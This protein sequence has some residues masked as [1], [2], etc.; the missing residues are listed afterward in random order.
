MTGPEHQSLFS[1]CDLWRGRL[2]HPATQCRTRLLIPAPCRHE[3]VSCRPL[4]HHEPAKKTQGRCLEPGLPR[5]Y[6]SS[7]GNLMLRPWENRAIPRI[8]AL[9]QTLDGLEFDPQTRIELMRFAPA[10]REPLPA[11]YAR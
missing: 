6:P 7:A 1:F 11:P 5:Q 3:F 4:S 9:L 8:S 10:F 2:P